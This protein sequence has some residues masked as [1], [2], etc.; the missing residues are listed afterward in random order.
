[1]TVPSPSLDNGDAIPIMKRQKYVV[2]KLKTENLNLSLE[3]ATPLV[4]GPAPFSCDSPVATNSRLA[5]VLVLV[6]CEN[7]H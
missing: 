7:H 2:H 3:P 6:A 5:L 4:F 1:M